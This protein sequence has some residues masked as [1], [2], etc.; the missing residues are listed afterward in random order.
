M[1]SVR[2]T[3]SDP[4]SST[5]EVFLLGRFSMH[6]FSSRSCRVVG[7]DAEGDHFRL[8]IRN[9]GLLDVL[10]GLEHAA[11]IVGINFDEL[12]QQSP[13]K[14]R[15]FSRPARSW[16]TRR[17]GGSWRGPLDL[18]LFFQRK[19]LD[20]SRLQRIGKSPV[21]SRTYGDPAGHAGGEVAAGRSPARHGSVRSMYSQPWSPTASTTA[22]S[23]CCGRRSARRPCPARKPLRRSRRKKPRS[24]R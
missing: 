2:E 7:V 21:S 3:T 17:G 10:D 18:V 12:G 22:W 9:A 13:P 8:F 19:E 23:R 6:L 24:R 5:L 4:D 16:C 14:G 20:I 15:G 1:S 11:I